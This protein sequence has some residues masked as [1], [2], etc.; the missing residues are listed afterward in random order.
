MSPTGYGASLPSDWELFP[1]LNLPGS[2]SIW[3]RLQVL[4]AVL[5]RS[6]STDFWPHP[7]S[8]SSWYQAPDD[9]RAMARVVEA[10]HRSVETGEWQEV[11]VGP[12]GTAWRFG[13]ALALSTPGARV[14]LD[15]DKRLRERPIS[16]CWTP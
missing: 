9:V 6:A 8:G 1:R 10:V 11:S 14:V 4:Q 16:P 13:L 2:K 7:D 3:N 12:A 15:G 5:G